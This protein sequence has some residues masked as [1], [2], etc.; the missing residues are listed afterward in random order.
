MVPVMRH[1]LDPLATLAYRLW[2]RNS[3]GQSIDFSLSISNYAAERVGWHL[4][5]PESE[6]EPR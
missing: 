1:V 6:W 4:L 5:R 3:R 2:R